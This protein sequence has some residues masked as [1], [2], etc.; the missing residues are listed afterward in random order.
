MDGASESGLLDLRGEIGTVKGWP[1]E[2]VGDVLDSAGF[3]PLGL[4]STSNLGFVKAP[5]FCAV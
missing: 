5:V 3:V 1:A 4:T 2:E